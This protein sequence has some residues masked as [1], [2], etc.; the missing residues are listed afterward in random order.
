MTDVVAV[1]AAAQSAE[2]DELARLLA[3]P[4]M[5]AKQAAAVKHAGLTFDVRFKIGAAHIDHSPK[6][7]AALTGKIARQLGV[8]PRQLNL[9]LSRAPSNTTAEMPQQK[10]PLEPSPP[11]LQTAVADVAVK[12]IDADDGAELLE[13]LQGASAELEAMGVQVL[14]TSV[15]GVRM[16]AEKSMDRCT[17]N[18]IRASELRK[19]VAGHDRTSLSLPWW[20]RSASDWPWSIIFW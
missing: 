12:L 19:E 15:R 17:F 11:K 6:G 3:S 18:F 14:E 20:T 13:R 9:S 10:Q 4:R 7:V 2:W 8:S 5:I 1:L 16:N